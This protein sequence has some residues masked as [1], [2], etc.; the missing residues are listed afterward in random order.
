MNTK[1]NEMI[2]KRQ[3]SNYLIDLKSKTVDK[4]PTTKTIPHRAI[5]NEGK[6]NNK[7]T[8]KA[9]VP[10]APISFIQAFFRQAIRIG[11]D[12]DN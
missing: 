10:K 1:K 4:T 2:R 6:A 3:R 8:L 12:W 7:K 9:N 5:I 11:L